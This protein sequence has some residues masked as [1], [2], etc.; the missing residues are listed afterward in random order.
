MK[1]YLL[2]ISVC[3]VAILAGTSLSAQEKAL[4]NL[5]DVLTKIQ[6]QKARTGKLSHALQ[7][8]DNA[9]S[10]SPWS[11]DKLMVHEDMVRIIALPTEDSELLLK[12]L[13]ALGAE[14]TK[15]THG[16]VSAL[17][18]IA[19]VDQLESLASLRFARPEYKPK[20]NFGDVT[21][22]GD[23]ALR[24]DLARATYGV[25]G[26]GVRIG[27]LSNSFD[28]LGDAAAGVASG[29]LPG[30]G[31][32][33]GF[34]QEVVVLS[35]EVNPDT[36]SFSV[37]EGRAMAEI[38]HDIAPGA[39]IYYYSAF[40][41]YFDFAAGIRALADAECDIIVD[42]IFYLAEPYFQ[43]GSIAQAV[44]DVTSQGVAYF[45]S[46]G[47]GARESFESEFNPIEIN[48]ST[49]HD[50]G[51]GNIFQT[52]TLD[53]SQSTFLWFQ[54]DDPSIFAAPNN[55]GLPGEIYDGPCPDTDL[56]ILIFDANTG[57]WLNPFFGGNSDNI[58]FCDNLEILEIVNFTGVVQEIAIAVNIFTGPN[59]RVFKYIDFGQ[60]APNENPN[61][62][63][64][65]V[66]HANAL[67][68]VAVGAS[69]YFNTEE[70]GERPALINGFSSVGGVPL[71]LNAD[72]SPKTHPEVREKPL[73]TGPDGGNNT[74]FGFDIE[75]DGFPNFFGTSASA[76]HVAAITAL[77]KEAHP[78][79][80]PHEINEILVQTASDMD[81]P[82]T[83][84][85]D[86]GFDFKT[87][88][89][90]VQA[91]AAVAAVQS[92]PSIYRFELVN[93]VANRVISTIREG[94]T[95]STLDP[96]EPSKV[97]IVARVSSGNG[98][99]PSA[100]EFDLSGDRSFSNSDASSPFALFGDVDGNFNAWRSKDGL[101]TISASPAGSSATATVSFALIDQ[102]PGTDFFVVDAD[103]DF[104][105][106]PLGDVL[107]LS[108]APSALTIE[109]LPG[110]GFFSFNDFFIENVRL[111]LSG[112]QSNDRI[113]SV[114]PYALFG[115]WEGNY[116][117]WPGSGPAP[118][119]YE[120][121]AIESNFLPGVPPLTYTF[122]DFEVVSGGGGTSILA[123]QIN[124]LNPS[125][126]PGE[127][128]LFPNPTSNGQVNLIWNTEGEEPIDV[129]VYSF[130]GQQVMRYR[131]QGG[132]T[133]QI[134][135][136]RMPAGTYTVR[137][138]SG[139]LDE[140]RRIVHK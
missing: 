132:F 73:I 29:D 136:S 103:T 102:L 59:P 28:A 75:G 9:R 47:N 87:G 63:G 108:T 99:E 125:A 126:E 64:T 100:V 31:N 82:E 124:G 22:Q 23:V 14:S 93:A 15:L 52:I 62:S 20:T 79:L 78:G 130:T 38:V 42:D 24:A 106:F 112:A 55:L 46:A 57:E 8:M 17:F 36:L 77:M 81:D 83:L 43:D 27:I 40:N 53:T 37:D 89:G 96:F 128:Y 67:G 111:Q 139:S 114:A 131:Y 48:G 133:Q 118:G 80:A 107:D 140:T 51:E 76:P 88:Y 92:G 61:P 86:E 127:L 119:E 44:D 41:G 60:I 6:R 129:T 94:Q 122:A 68:A 56:D 25:D 12:D 54:W 105:A 39:E 84:E 7:S 101:Y 90:F 11:S 13:E 113:E 104:G 135:L 4:A 72:G 70:F 91:D 34:T 30:A 95:L 138:T 18:P 71:Y 123:S 50:F 137:L 32:P 97:N 98:S 121:L 5:P 19:N 74:F 65:C 49:F 45:S 21:S 109:Y 85:F 26:S 116:F 115:D 117:P 2:P 35:E 110:G 1:F 134:D 58:T 33:N 3:L 120:L 10:A 16:V 66:G 69:A